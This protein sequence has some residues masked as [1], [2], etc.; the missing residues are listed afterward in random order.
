MCDYARLCFC[1]SA[2]IPVLYNHTH[3]HICVH[4]WADISSRTDGH[5]TKSSEQHLL[6]LSFHPVHAV[7][8]RIT[9]THLF[10]DNKLH[11]RNRHLG[12]IVDF[13]WHF[14]MDFQWHCPADFQMGFRFCEIWRAVFCP[15]F[16]AG[17]KAAAG[18][19]VAARLVAGGL[20]AAVLVAAVELRAETDCLGQSKA[21]DHQTSFG[22]HYL[23][24]ATCLMRPRVL[25]VF[26]SVKDD[27]TLLHY[28]PRLKKPV[29]DN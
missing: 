23:S 10:R 16:W 4:A 20:V 29:L 15:D 22:W 9:S 19:L 24:N 1:V 5:R 21:Q 2:Y 17:A 13:Q 26:C 11:T 12:I 8:R 7:L 18:G 28:S 6:W 3:T 14:P 27:H 25:C